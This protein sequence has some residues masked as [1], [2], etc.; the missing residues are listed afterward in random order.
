MLDNRRM[1][2]PHVAALALLA[3]A[4][5][6]CAAPAPPPPHD[7]PSETASTA[8]DATPDGRGGAATTVIP[9]VPLGAPFRLSFDH[10]VRI[11]KSGVRLRFAELLED[12]RCPRGV[13]C[14]QAGRVRARLQVIPTQGELEMRLSRGR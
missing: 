5:L 13:Q 1:A 2:A 8:V 4:P 7:V 3:L 6:A 11:G 14:I 10:L 9:V 12:S